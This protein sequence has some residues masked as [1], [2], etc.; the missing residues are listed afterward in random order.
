MIRLNVFV[1]VEEKN[2]EKVLLV[3]NLLVYLQTDFGNHIMKLII[4]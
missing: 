3:E 2:R 4:Y 1:Q